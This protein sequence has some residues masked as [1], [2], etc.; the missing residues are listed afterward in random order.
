MDGASFTPGDG[1]IGYSLISHQD[2]LMQKQQQA[3]LEPPKVYSEVPLSVS[4]KQTYQDLKSKEL[5][6]T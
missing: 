2:Y 4:F 5:S 6:K 3:M 1:H